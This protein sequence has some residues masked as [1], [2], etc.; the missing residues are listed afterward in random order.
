MD[1]SNW[2]YLYNWDGKQWHRANL[3]YTPYVSSDKKTLCMSF[4]RDRNYHTNDQENDVWSQ[5]LLTERFLREMKFYGIASKNNIPTL[6]IIDTDEIKR[7]I[8]L[9]WYGEDFFMQGNEVLPNWKE[10]W[11]QRI[12]EMWAAN[13]YKFSLHPNSWVAHD[14]VLI[15][16][17]WFF[18]FD[19]NETI[20]IKDFLIQISS[21]RQE[22]MQEFLKSLGFDMDSSYDPVILQA[23]AFNSFRANYPEELI[24]EAL[25]RNALLQQNS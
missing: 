9:E 21:E 5:E 7:H 22:K 15:P 6:K 14:G 16:F 1:F 2:N 17:N 4:N 8:F 10:Q 24:N 13:I 23:L 18:S 3:V 12:N 11:L 20:I 25:K 19:K